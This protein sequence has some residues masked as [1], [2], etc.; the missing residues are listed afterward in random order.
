MS[1]LEDDTSPSQISFFLDHETPNVARIFNHFLDGTANFEV[2]RRAGQEML[3]VVPSLA[4]WVRLQRA[5]MQEAVQRLSE[6][7][8]AQFIDM[9]SGLPMDDYMHMLL[10]DAHVVYSD[11]NPVA[12]NYGQALFQGNNH[13][14]YLYADGRN[15]L[16]FLQNKAVSKLID[17]QLP[18]AFGL[19]FLPL[20]LSLD[21]LHTLTQHL[22]NWV[23]DVGRLFLGLQTMG[24]P[25]GGDAYVQ[26]QQMTANAG[27]PLRHYRLQETIEA[28][29]PWQVAVKEP[30]LSFLN[31]PEDVITEEDRGQFRFEYHA[32]IMVK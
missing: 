16:P 17:A 23:G 15:I 5:F 12:I 22:Y 31:L 9:G 25:D 7:G 21:E 26:F 20:V 19:N 10:P 2:D 30:I 4:K 18:V 28:L 27:I 11:I 29:H 6:E 3:Q 32:L 14:S 24:L 13:V 8:L 1:N